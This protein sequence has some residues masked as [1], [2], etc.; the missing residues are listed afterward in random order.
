MFDMTQLIGEPTRITGTTS[1]VLDL[2]MVNDTDKILQSGTFDLGLS[3]HLLIHCTRKRQKHLVN[4]H[5]HV[6][7]RTLKNYTKEAFENKLTQVD[8]Q[9][10]YDCTE[11]DQAWCAFKSKFLSVIDNIAPFRQIRVKLNTE[12]WMTGEILHLIHERDR[13]LHK[14]KKLKEHSWYDKY[15]YY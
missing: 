14:F 5:N 13:L 7:I 12:P 1:S 15:I 11:V 3:D 9:E 6:N 8:W 2:I 4:E 10:I